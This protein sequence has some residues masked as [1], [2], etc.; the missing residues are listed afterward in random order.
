MPYKQFCSP[1]GTAVGGQ[2]EDV[3][4]Q[5]A[6]CRAALRVLTDVWFSDSLCKCGSNQ[7]YTFFSTLLA[8]SSVSDGF[9]YA[10]SNKPYRL[11]DR[12][13][14]THPFSFQLFLRLWFWSTQQIRAIKKPQCVFWRRVFLTGRERK[15]RGGTRRRWNGRQEVTSWTEVGGSLEGGSLIWTHSCDVVLQKCMRASS[16]DRLTVSH[17]WS[18]HKV[19][20]YSGLI[21]LTHIVQIM[22]YF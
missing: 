14:Y 18:P 22:S 8:S 21:L 4:C 1:V 3:Y 11:L 17:T 9:S 19:T 5:Q 20:S 2:I 12:V 16:L 13:S 7:L 15:D 6:L 10:R